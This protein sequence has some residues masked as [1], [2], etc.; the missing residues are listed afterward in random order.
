VTALFP[1]ARLIVQRNEWAEL[2]VLHPIQRRWYQP[3]TYRDLPPDS[4]VT[5]DGDVMLGPGVALIDTPGHVTGNQSL[6]LNTNTGIWT[7]SENVIAAECLEPKHSKIPGLAKRAQAWGHD[8]VVNANT[9]DAMA[10]QYNSIMLEKAIA[11]RSQVDSRFVQF[12]P[13]SELTPQWSNPGTRPG[14]EHKTHHPPQVA[15]V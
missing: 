7:S 14:F 11:D 6:V 1:N 3:E 13:S 5:I 8:V 12:F 10:T 2:G 4:V 15:V 9:I